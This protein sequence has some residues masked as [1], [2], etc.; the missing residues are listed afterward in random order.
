MKIGLPIAP[1]EIVNIPE[2]LI[3]MSP[4]GLSPHHLGVGPAFGSVKQQVST[5]QFTQ[6]NSLPKE[7]MLNVLAF[8]FWIR[9]Q[10]RTLT[11]KS[12]NPNL[13]WNPGNSKI[14]VLDHNMAFDP[15]FN[16]DEFFE[17]HVFCCAKSLLRDSHDQRVDLLNRMTSALAGWDNIL[18]EIPIEW[19]FIDDEQTIEVTDIDLNEIRESLASTIQSELWLG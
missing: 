1:F 14:V 18:N 15:E 5:I 9:N 6:L 12:G 13:F 19:N 10:D 8:D 2:Q 17:F 11:E 7:L 3:S 16:K 4:S